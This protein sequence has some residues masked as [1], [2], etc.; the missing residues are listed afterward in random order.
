M[1]LYV[2]A[3][4][5]HREKDMYTLT[6]GEIQLIFTLGY[7]WALSIVGQ[8]IILF[9]C[10]TVA[11]LNMFKLAEILETTILSYQLKLVRL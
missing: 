9:P 8:K 3:L 1:H 7:T 4:L 6:E 11:L 5:I 2:F 10:V